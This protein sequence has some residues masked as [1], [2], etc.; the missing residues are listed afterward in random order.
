MGEFIAIEGNIGAGKTSLS[1]LLSADL[2]C[3]LLLEQFEDNSFLPKFYEDPAR[4]SFPLELSFLAERYQQ[5][6]SNADRS[7]LFNE[8]LVADYFIHKCLVFAGANLPE[9]EFRLYREFFY[10]ASASVV[11]P[12]KLV[13][14]HMDTP[15]LLSNIA[16]RGRSYESGIRADY[17]DRISEGYFQFFKQLSP[18]REQTVLILD[19][20]SLDFVDS[21]EHYHIIKEAILRSYTP[22]IHRLVPGESL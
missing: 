5:L 4:Y 15:R 9:D 19:I 7:A 12:S 14:L 2:G 6:R 20:N 8:Y 13:F 18:S 22:G 21:A 11:H 16:K 3:R 1:K 17:L 10:M